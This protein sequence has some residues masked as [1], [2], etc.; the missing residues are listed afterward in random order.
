MKTIEIFIAELDVIKSGAKC[1]KINKYYK[2][3]SKKGN[4]ILVNSVAKLNFSESS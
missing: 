3:K 4:V 2:P 1:A